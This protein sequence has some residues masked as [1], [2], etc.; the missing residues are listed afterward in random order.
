MSS[1]IED[2]YCP[3]KIKRAVEPDIKIILKLF[4]GDIQY[5]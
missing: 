1:V 3:V 2:H 4:T 5:V